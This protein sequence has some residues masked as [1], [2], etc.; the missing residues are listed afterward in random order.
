MEGNNSLEQKDKALEEAFEAMVNEKIANS[1]RNN[2]DEAVITLKDG[3]GAVI[4]VKI[5]KDTKPD[6][7]KIFMQ[8]HS[9]ASISS[10]GKYK[11]ALPLRHIDKETPQ[12]SIARA[13]AIQ[14]ARMQQ[15]ENPTNSSAKTEKELNQ[16]MKEGRTEVIRTGREITDGEDF[17]MLA[18]RMFG[19]DAYEVYRVRGKDAHGFKYIAK[20]T[21][22]EYKEFGGTTTREGTNPLQKIHILKKDG[23]I[24]EKQVDHLL[25][26]GRYAIATDIPD[27]AISDRPRTLIGN[28]LQSGEYLFIEALDSRNASASEN[29]M[30]REMIDRSVSRLK[31]ED[32]GSAI[33][34]AKRIRGI[35][36]D[37]KISV[38]EI[39]LVKKLRE[40]GYDDE[41]IFTTIDTIH[42][43]KEEGLKDTEIKAILDSVETTAKQIE[44]M[45]K[46]NITEEKQKEIFKRMYGEDKRN[47]F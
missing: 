24:E 9:L 2:K 19:V 42:D 10:N 14:N 36:Q 23:T 34:L 40:N 30:I 25:T 35:T 22:G 26:N 11:Y 32:I 20:T 18:Q 17:H 45:E 44:E 8:G 16:A 7:Y 28:I 27:S 1:K 39:E 13:I 31:L 37:S 15:K 46:A 12:F 21:S 29:M 33:E 6:A 3:K 43:L 38:E 41:E 4:L 47:I 5:Q